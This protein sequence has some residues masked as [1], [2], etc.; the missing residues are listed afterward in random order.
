MPWF[1]KTNSGTSKHHNFLL[2][3]Q[4]SCSAVKTALPQK[5]QRLR[6]GKIRSV[7]MKF[8]IDT[9]N[10]NEIREAAAFGFADGVTT[11]PSLIAKEG[12]VDFKQHIAAICEI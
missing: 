7:L 1:A 2:D 9:A 5:T 3:F 12:G 11:N 4:H 8:F 10:L 6:R